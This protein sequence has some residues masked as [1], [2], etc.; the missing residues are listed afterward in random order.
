VTELRSLRLYLQ[1]PIVPV[2]ASAMQIAVALDRL[3]PDVWSQQVVG[4]PSL[5]AAT[6]G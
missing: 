4:R 5:I 1:T 2:L 3:L 6:Y